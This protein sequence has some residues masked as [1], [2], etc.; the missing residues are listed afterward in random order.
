MY[1]K[2]SDIKTSHTD[3]LTMDEYTLFL[4]EIENQ[5]PFRRNANREQDYYDG[6]QLDSELLQRLEERGLPPATEPLIG[7]TIDSV[8][9]IEAK[10]RTDWRVVADNDA[11][12]HEETAKALDYKLNQAE[13]RSG[14]DKGCADGYAGLI[15]VGWSWVEVGRESDPFKFPYRVQEIPRNEIFWDIAARRSDLSDARWLIRQR[16]VHV[17]TVAQI[18]PDKG[19]QFLNKAWQMDGSVTDGLIVDDIEDY[20]GIELY[21]VWATDRGYTVEEERWYDGSCDNVLLTEVWYRRWAMSDLIRTPDGRVLEFEEDN[22]EHR[23]LIQGGAEFFQEITSKL[24]RAYVVGATI[25]NDGP[26]PYKHQQF[27]YVPFFG[28][29][30][31]RTGVPYGLI[32][33][34]IFLQDEVNARTSKMQWL[35]SATRTIRTD[36]A[37]ID[38]DVTFRKMS[39]AP[40]ADIVLDANHMAQ[41]GAVF[42]M[43]FLG[44]LNQHQYQRLRD[45]REALQAVAGVTPG[46]MGKSTSGQDTA[47]GY[48]QMVEQSN[49]TLATLL[50]HAK[51]ART[52]VGRLLLA[53][54]IDDLGD[55]RE[56]VIITSQLAEKQSIILNDVFLDE[57]G[58][59]VRTNDIQRTA[60]QVVLADV[61]STPSFQTQQ[62]D[63]MTRTYETSPDEFKAAL[64]P[65]LIAMQQVAHKE[66]L[67]QSVKDAQQTP[68][69]EQIQQ[70]IEAAVEEQRRKDQHDLKEREIALKERKADAEIEKIVSETVENTL[71]SFFSATQAAGQVAAMPQVVPIADQMLDSAGF[72][73]KSTPAD[74][75]IFPAPQE[76]IVPPQ[77]VAQNTSPQFPPR[78]P[79]PEQEIIPE[80]VPETINQP[81]VNEGIEKP[82]VQI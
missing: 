76:P 74:Q 13:R 8:L 3:P 23:L 82:G 75:S 45:A 73:D 4:D 41:K 16:W 49:Q 77:P 55:K 18:F 72:E 63:S 19:K 39:T 71:T 38:D 60:M 10:N 34:M 53:L 26:T 50:D 25:L 44:D 20:A 46:F 69:P 40:N 54:I 27:P 28:K 24:R 36:G 79:E 30:E 1:T 65:H 47:S 42:D 32:R 37:V 57:Q 6:N 9:G 58:Q 52:Q 81:I 31:D 67:L 51:R 59:E 78:P 22:E 33:G 2:K 35:L 68:T 56:E 12:E 61:P 64:F 5:P 66:E 15:K 48:S 29:R 14:A 43:D 7:S 80:V 21:N 62:L 70:Q 11:I 17:N